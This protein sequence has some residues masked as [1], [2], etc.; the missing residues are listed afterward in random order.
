MSKKLLFTSSFSKAK[1]F[2]IFDQINL[3]KQLSEIH[4]HLLFVVPTRRY[5]TLLERHFF[6]YLK[7][8]GFMLPVVKT[9]DEIWLELIHVNNPKLKFEKKWQREFF[10]LS[11]LKQHPEIIYNQ[12][13]NS[14]IQFFSQSILFW[15]SS[16]GKTNSINEISYLTENEWID[17]NRIQRFYDFYQTYCELSESSNIISR[18]RLR[19]FVSEENSFFSQFKTS[20]FLSIDEWIYDNWKLLQSASVDCENVVFSLD[21]QENSETPNHLLDAHSYLLSTGFTEIKSDPESAPVREIALN[22]FESKVEEVDRIASQILNL[23]E[24][25]NIPLHEICLV[26]R[27]PQHYYSWIQKIF[28]DK[29]L[30]FNFS[31]G[32][33]VSETSVAKL[34]LLIKSFCTQQCDSIAL[35]NYLTHPLVNLSFLTDTLDILIVEF[36]EQSGFLEWE[37]ICDQFLNQVKDEVYIQSLDQS[38]QKRM[39]NLEKPVETL[40]KVISWLFVQIMQINDAAT[41][42]E[43]QKLIL[44]WMMN[45]INYE[46]AKDRDELSFG[47]WTALQ[48]IQSGF[49]Q[50]TEFD[51]NGIEFSSSDYFHALE[52]IILSSV[53][54]EPVR[55]GVQILGPLEVKG[56]NFNSLFFIG[57]HSRI[58]PE[59][60]SFQSFFTQKEIEIIDSSYLNNLQKIER[61]EFQTIL[62]NPQN[63]AYLTFSPHPEFPEGEASLFVEL[64]KH[65]NEIK[66]AVYNPFYDL[67]TK[68]TSG[69]AKNSIQEKFNHFSEKMEYVEHLKNS[70][71]NTKF[72]GMF[73]SENSKRKL[74]LTYFSKKEAFS[75]TDF[76]NYAVCGFKYYLEKILAVY[77]KD[78][79]SEDLDPRIKGNILHEVV[80][81]FYTGW[82]DQ[83][84]DDNIETAWNHISKIV[85]EK[86]IADVSLNLNTFAKQQFGLKLKSKE[87]SPLFGFLEAEKV[88]NVFYEPF[89]FEWSFGINKDENP[90]FLMIKS[91]R[92]DIRIKGRIDRIDKVKSD[93]GFVC[94]DYKTGGKENTT[95]LIRHRKSF[96]FPIYNLAINEFLGEVEANW[97]Y[98]LKKREETSFDMLQGFWGTKSAYKKFTPKGRTGFESQ[99]FFT[100]EIKSWKKVISETVDQMKV[101]NFSLNHTAHLEGKGLS[102]PTHCAFETI[103]RKDENR[104]EILF[105]TEGE[106]E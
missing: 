3:K 29:N 24:A 15:E 11:A 46:K 47:T 23:H 50:L 20:V 41:N 81:S 37:K 76:E 65:S 75:P 106:E 98:V 85:D 63:Q 71:E 74:D 99:E 19:G 89:Q 56:T 45:R 60:K 73:N 77:G 62:Q 94:Y 80:R 66:E 54:N 9:I 4:E 42:H 59:R 97:Y 10:I 2:S 64:L 12:S 33:P 31:A 57:L 91:N 32:F 28:Q 52:S 17:E 61:N 68:Q 104:I 58:Y 36:G 16:V 14:W 51:K 8:N 88:L 82:K 18:E 96:Q 70:G 22:K 48:V 5:K 27:E 83:I 25:G 7:Q 90:S 100:E 102:C 43:R 35:K 67:R 38:K 40:K 13:P 72:D 30:A 6:D 101:G 49:E 26:V 21:Y 87:I 93:S 53:W 86:L 55:D 103:C 95:E 34:V 78:E 39:R 1:I 69:L 105:G 79:F 92:G 84:T 44:N